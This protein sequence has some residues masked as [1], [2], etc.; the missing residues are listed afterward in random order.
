M[1][2]AQVEPLLLVEIVVIDIVLDHLVSL[3]FQ[4]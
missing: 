2:G 4:I 3:L 1:E